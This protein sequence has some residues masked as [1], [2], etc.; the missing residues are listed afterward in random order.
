VTAVDPARRL[1]ALLRGEPVVSGERLSETL[2]ISRAAIWKHVEQLRA[3]GYTIEAHHARGYR[4]GGIPDRLLPDEIA[5]RLT[6]ARIGRRIEHHDEIGSTN[7]EAMRLAREGAPEGTLVVAERQTQ[8]RGRLGRS[9]ISPPS[10]NLYASWVLRPTLPPAAAPQISLAAAVA[11]ARTLAPLAPGLVAIKWPNDCLLDGR[12]VAG[13]LTE[14]DAEL[15]RVRAVV[16]GIGVNLNATARAFPPELRATATSVRLATGRT[17]DRIAFT[18]A[19]C[20]ALEG[21]YD[22]LLQDGFEPLIAEWNQYSCLTGRAVTVDCAGRRTTGRVR[23]LDASGH[24]LLA[25]DDG[26][27]ERIVAGDVTLVGG[28]EGLAR[29]SGGA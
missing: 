16:L 17:V 25:T 6:T 15:D 11:V 29:R 14:M 18:A 7:V 1:L 24:L 4:L 3:R 2:G 21:V 9:W 20:D 28:Y 26:R 23:G 22:R 10:V 12:K 27:E 8:G 19:L 5:Q 13:I